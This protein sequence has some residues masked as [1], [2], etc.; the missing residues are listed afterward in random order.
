MDKAGIGLRAPYTHALLQTRQDVGFLEA[1][2]ENYF[3][4]SPAREQLVALANNYPISLHCVGLSLGRAD[5]LDKHHLQQFK[6]LVDEINPILVSE[7]LAWSSYQ[8]RHLPDLLPIPYTA[9]ALT[10]FCDHI[11]QMQDALGRSILIENPSNYLAFRQMDMSEAEFLNTLAEH[12]GCKILLD[13]NNLYLS[14]Q[15]VGLD[16]HQYINQLNRDFVGQYHLAGHIER[17]QENDRVLIDSHNQPVSDTV[18]TLYRE[19]L[20]CF[21]N[22]PTLIEWDSDFPP[23]ET[24]VDQA[25]QATQ[26]MV[27]EATHAPV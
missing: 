3:G 1:H 12:T 10:I 9:E 16:A 19:C 26:W 4:D 23:L 22:R 21:G 15:N 17:R 6:S 11:K 25:R 14:S 18:W 27:S 20:E 5:G 13:V 8:H 24:L 2:S 7:H